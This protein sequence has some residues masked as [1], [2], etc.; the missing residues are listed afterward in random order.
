MT[1]AV[2]QNVLLNP[3]K[4]SF[5]RAQASVL[6]AYLVADLIQVF[7][8]CSGVVFICLTSRVY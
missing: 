3:G 8:A 6:K 4:I 2:V 1:L 7:F 5:L